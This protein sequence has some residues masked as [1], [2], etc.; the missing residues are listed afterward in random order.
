LNKVNKIFLFLNII[1]SIVF[2]SGCSLSLNNPTNATTELPEDSIATSTVSDSIPTDSP[3]PP[4]EYVALV[5]G[6]GVPISSFEAS[7]TQ[8]NFALIEFPN[9]LKNGETPDQKV[10]KDLIYRQLLAQAAADAAYQVS[11]E[12]LLEK[13]NFLTE[14]IGGEDSLLAWIS[15][16]GYSSKA[17]L[18]YD[19]SVEIAATFQRN[20]ILE[21]V[22]LETE[23]TLAH[24][25]FFSDAYLASRAHDQ[26][27]AGVSWDIVRSNNDPNDYGYLGWFPRGYLLVAELD[28]IA[29]SLLPGG[30]SSVIETE[31]GYH[32]LYVIDRNE[33]V[34]LS[35][36]ALLGIKNSALTNWLESEY[37]NS[38]IEIL[39]PE[40]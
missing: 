35:P 2:L 1:L 20:R 10:L 17:A 14:K 18:L 4:P 33:K 25:L 26:L 15:E 12:L 28:E 32:I 24:Q 37:Q 19:L 9:L 39:L 23:Q 27:L 22:P 13:L 6:V 8:L 30:F 11:A 36:D 40:N 3:I 21:S 16:N 5:D 29:F 7:L 31:I 38:K 34:L